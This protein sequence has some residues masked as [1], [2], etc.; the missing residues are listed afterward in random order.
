MHLR[1]VGL[2]TCVQLLTAAASVC[3]AIAVVHIFG[4]TRAIEVFFAA[5]VI[6]QMMLRLLQTGQLFEVTLP[7]Y[8]SVRNG[9]G[10]AAA[11][12]V[13]SLVL[14]WTLCIATAMAILLW[15][16]APLLV[17]LATPGFS[18]ADRQVALWMFRTLVP[19]VIIQVASGLLTALGNA[20]SAFGRFEAM[21]LIA[22]VVSLAFILLAHETLG[23]W[24]M[25]V[26][27]WIN[28]SLTLLGRL[29]LVA[30]SGLRYY[31]VL[32]SKHL[33]I[34]QV[35]KNVISGMPTVFS[36]S[37]LNLVVVSQL[38]LL[39]VGS[40][41]V[42]QYAQS[43]LLKLRGLIVRPTSVVFFTDIADSVGHYVEEVREKV[44]AWLHQFILLAS[45][46]IAILWTPLA[47]LLAAVLHSET[48]SLQHVS[49]TTMILRC[50]LPSLVLTGI[51][52]IYQKLNVSLL[53]FRPQYVAM[54][55]G[56][57]IAAVIAWLV[58]GRFGL[59]GFVVA[60]FAHSFIYAVASYS[61]TFVWQSDY[62]AV[63]KVSF[64]LRCAALCVLA[65]FAGRFVSSLVHTILPAPELDRWEFLL[66]GTGAL[67]L[68]AVITVLIAWLLGVGEIRRLAAVGNS[69]L[70]RLAR[71]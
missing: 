71:R 36:G 22:I 16:V 24:V 15:F 68:Q 41:A 67:L 61:V 21:G 11:N 8:I 18:D 13:A 25:V 32:R 58:I 10:R 12:E 55:F 34:W 43:F 20:E 59:Y 48:F 3:Q 70:R 28:Q 17:S 60:F 2:L 39:P 6:Q 49:Q 7:N 5:S 31:P 19:L 65:I 9:A 40:L 47:D 27:L 30:I 66:A 57:L 50:L 63:A 26:A 42:A 46:S 1:R 52:V 23:A 54:F 33:S 37:L 53:R 64:L 14:N 45:L 4:A 38:S 29:T 35:Y 69:Q 56:N 44:T 51:G 62:L